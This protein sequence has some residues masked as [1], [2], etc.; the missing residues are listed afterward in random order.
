MLVGKSVR[1]LLQPAEA[2]LIGRE[3]EEEEEEE[4]INS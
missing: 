4:D 1:S 2:V 3:K